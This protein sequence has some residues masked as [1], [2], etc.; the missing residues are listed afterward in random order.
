[1]QATK[2]TGAKLFLAAK[3]HEIRGTK[4]F[5]ELAKT[6]LAILQG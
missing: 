6:T 4:I 1:M 5:D 3:A 2:A